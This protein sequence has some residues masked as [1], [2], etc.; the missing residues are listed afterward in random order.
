M[1]GRVNLRE[2]GTFIHMHGSHEH[3]AMHAAMHDD[4]ARSISYLLRFSDACPGCGFR[5]QRDADCA[6]C[7]SV[8]CPH[9][10]V[11]FRCHMVVG[12][13]HSAFMHDAAA[14]VSSRYHV[15][16]LLE[17]AARGA[18]QVEASR[19][20]LVHLPGYD[21]LSTLS[22]AFA[23]IANGRLS[24]TMSDLHRALADHNFQVSD[25]ELKMLWLRYS[26]TNSHEVKFPD[27]ASQL[28]TRPG[29]FAR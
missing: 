14:P 18:E 1:P 22:D 12:D 17:T 20:Q 16:K 28:K 29:G 15:Y 26:P 6:G 4:E 10:G 21:V 19:K 5:V 9:C 23:Q 8:R 27:Y 7:P 3:Q 13:H 24:F 11:S 25:Q 2:L